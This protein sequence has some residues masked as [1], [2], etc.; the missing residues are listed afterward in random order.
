MNA[1]LGYFAEI[2]DEGVKPALR[3]PLT[4]SYWLGVETQAS[5]ANF[6]KYPKLG[7]QY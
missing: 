1:L 6:E 4:A 3:I 5:K 2:K 7:D